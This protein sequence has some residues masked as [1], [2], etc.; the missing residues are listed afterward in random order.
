MLCYQNITA[1]YSFSGMFWIEQPWQPLGQTIRVRPSGSQ[2]E[3]VGANTANPS[4]HF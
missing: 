3:V 4:S 1:L 2:A